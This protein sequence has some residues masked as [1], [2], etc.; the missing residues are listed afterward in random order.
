MRKTGILFLVIVMVIIVGVN[1]FFFDRWLERRL[2]SLG[3]RIIGAKVELSGLE[4]SL[5]NMKMQWNRLQITDPDDTWRNLIETGYCVFHI[6]PAPLLSKKVI[7][8]EFQIQNVQFGSQR[9]TD[10]RLKKKNR[11]SPEEQPEIILKLKENLQ[12]EIDQIPLFNQD[13]LVLSVDFESTL[14]ASQLQSPQKLQILQE[15]FENRY[16]LLEDRLNEAGGEQR[17]EDLETQINSIN[18]DK[19]DTPQELISTMKT[20]DEINRD[21]QTRISDLKVIQTEF[22][23]DRAIVHKTR[24][25]VSEWIEEDYIQVYELA[26]LPDIS[27]KNV[28][29]MLFGERII[30][31]IDRVTRYFGIAHRV[32]EIVRAVIPKKKKIPRFQGQDIPFMG[33]SILPRF[34]IKNMQLSG[35]TGEGINLSG[36]IKNIVSKQD[37]IGQPTH[38]ELQGV[39]E[40]NALVKLNGVM[41][42]RSDGIEESF[43]LH[44]ENIPL[45]DVKLSVFPL[46]HEIESGTGYF[47]SSLKYSD[48]SFQTDVEF[49]G[50]SITF[51]YLTKTKP[52]SMDSDLYQ[53]SVDLAKEIHEIEFFASLE[54]LTSSFDFNVAS[55][56]DDIVAEKIGRVL[57]EELESAHKYLREKVDQE[58]QPYKLEFEQY[59]E[60]RENELIAEL[61]TMDRENISLKAMEEKKREEIKSRLQEEK[62]QKK[63]EDEVLE[64]MFDLFKK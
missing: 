47:A 40:D 6:T 62:E 34:W 13:G 43:K 60:R 54:Q 44:M 51:D 61:T 24:Y 59:L 35:V 48:Y 52:E 4:I 30:Q 7:I 55:N 27:V 42:H 14:K 25:D 8:E 58:I 31:R 37:L 18:V 1:L 39:R 3:E 29:K 32:T 57:S 56:L 64:Q 36:S 23:A 2:E 63:I 45:N 5:F 46:F 12:N 15:E 33:N 53:V 21:I 49:I 41:D 11:V 17:F 9:S 28:G 50:E 10:G 16:R 20:L 19:L 26:Q 38:I 22:E